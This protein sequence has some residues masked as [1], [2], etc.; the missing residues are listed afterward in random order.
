[1]TCKN[2]KKKKKKFHNK[3]VNGI[4]C[5]TLVVTTTGVDVVNAGRI[6]DVNRSVII[7]SVEVLTTEVESSL[8]IDSIVVMMGR[9][10]IDVDL[11]VVDS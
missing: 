2:N 5:I 8:T 9:S 11:E 7:V 6:V 10:V 4:Y 1:M 3:Y